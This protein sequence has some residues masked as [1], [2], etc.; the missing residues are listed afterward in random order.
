ML[1]V[2]FLCT[3]NSARSILGE[4][5]LRAK[6]P[7]RFAAFSAGS[8]PRG[9]INPDA[10]AFLAS[11]GISTE[12][13][14]SKSWDVFAEP[15]TPAMDLIFTVCDSAAAEACPFWPGHPA[16]VHWGVPDPAGVAGDEAARLAAF[17]A[18]FKVISARIDRMLALPMERLTPAERL[19][20]LKAIAQEVS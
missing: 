2:L 14:S 19:A 18:A 3:A 8:Q 20:A 11:E 1:N 15:G 9:A 17:A 13:L 16:Q 6:A 5:Y 10:V 4:A 7:E 12:G